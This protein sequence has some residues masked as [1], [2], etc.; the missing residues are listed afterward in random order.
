[1]KINSIFITFAILLN[2]SGYGQSVKISEDF[3]ISNKIERAQIIGKSSAGIIIRKMGGEEVL[4]IYNAQLRLLRSRTIEMEYGTVI[5][6]ELNGDNVI[7][8]FVK[9]TSTKTY[10]YSSIFNK[11][12]TVSEEGKLLDSFDNV[13]NS[14]S[15]NFKV[16]SS[17]GGLYT[18]LIYG[19]DIEDHVSK[20]DLSLLNFNGDKIYQ[21]SLNIQV[22]GEYQ[23]YLRKAI[24]DL[25]ANIYLFVERVIPNKTKSDILSFEVFKVSKDKEIISEKIIFEKDVFDIPKF[26]LDVKNKNLVIHAL[27]DESVNGESGSTGVLT[28]KIRTS[29]MKTTLK[30]H[31]KYAK[32]FISKLTGKDTMFVQEKLLTFKIKDV[33]IDVQGNS[34][35]LA[36]SYFQSSQSVQVTNQMFSPSTYPEYKNVN[37][38]NYNDVVGF[39]I[40]SVGNIKDYSI[41]RKKQISEEDGG[42]YSSYMIGNN[43]NSLN[44]IHTDQ[45]NGSVDFVLQKVKSDQSQVRNIL[46]A[47]NDKNNAVIVKMGKQISLNEVLIPCYKNNF[48]KLIKVTL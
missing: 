17:V 21:T 28:Y 37:I 34:V 19:K 45:V 31:S 9:P 12:L 18:G 46:I 25:E 39:W 5:R 41:F 13:G 10:L 3:K 4:E 42:I 32:S 8:Y 38:Y 15:R 23:H 30:T 20:L 24:V 44:I 7:Y 47:D 43:G 29:D 2:Y 35:I 16:V 48:F 33:A 1:M 11:D 6:A 14:P 27:I 26:S 22:D 40:D 36:E